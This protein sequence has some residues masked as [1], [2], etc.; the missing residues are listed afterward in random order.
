V[1]AAALVPHPPLLV[2]ALAAGA[3]PLV[4]PLLAA[5]DAVVAGLIER[6]PGTVVLVGAGERT[7]THED[8]DTGTLAG[9]GVAVD[10][11]G[12]V[13]SSAPESERLPLSLSI[14]RW[15]LARARRTGWDGTVVLQE[16]AAGTPAE[17]CR[18]LGRRLA[19]E[20]GPDTAWLAL[21]DGSTRRGSRSPGHDDP[22]AASFDASVA[23]AFEKADL[24]ALFDL[25]AVLAAELGAAGRPV[26]QALAGAVGAAAAEHNWSAIEATVHYDDAPFGVE[27][28]VADW[29]PRP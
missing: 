23:Q 13:D 18:L 4:A 28:L 20:T 7:R 19:A 24:Q 25:D 26:W 10:P 27:Y 21:A 17:E 5:C 11:V 6:E 15:L 22:R 29:R 2:P 8:R 1:L 16:I 14:G 9:F 3:A 12:Q